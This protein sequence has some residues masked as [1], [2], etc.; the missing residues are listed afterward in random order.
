MRDGQLCFIIRVWDVLQKHVIGTQIRGWFIKHRNGSGPLVKPLF[1]NNNSPF[2]LWPTTL[3]H[4]INEKSP[5]YDLSAKDLLDKKYFNLETSY[6]FTSNHSLNR[7]NLQNRNHHSS[8]RI[9]EIVRF[10]DAK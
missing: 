5:L 2:I 6:V 4:T 7:I 10:D 9:G 8:H 3:Q 1:F